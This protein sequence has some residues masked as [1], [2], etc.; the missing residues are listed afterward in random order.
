[1]IDLHTHTRYSDGTWSVR[2]LLEEAEK[3][4][5]EILSI[6]DHDTL[7]AYK[8]L[9]KMKI[10]E[11]YTGEILTGVELT[12]V[13]EG[14]SFHLLAY[15]FDYP[16]LESYL[17]ENYE[18]KEPDLNKE[19][20]CMIESCKKNSIQIDT[21]AYDTSKGWPVDVIFPEIKK[22]KEN[23]KY[24]KEEEWNNIDVF[25]NACIT[26]PKFPAAVDFSIHYPNAKTVSNAVR[27]AGGKLFIAHLFRYNLENPMEFLN[28]LKQEKIIDGVEVEHACFTKEQNRILKDYCKNNTLLMSGG[29]DCHGEKKADRKIGIGYGNMYIHKNLIK[30]WYYTS[31]NI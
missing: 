28:K 18:R 3:N 17:Y 30:E 21:I 6:T 12:T 9:E 25:F 4:K 7:K 8:E 20:A 16:T 22:H 1:L 2:E 13:Y 31:T 24:F 15:D 27:K 11:I 19:F 14:I 10:E 26:N 23:R 5:I 29:T